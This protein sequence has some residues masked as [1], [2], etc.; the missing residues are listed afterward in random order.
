VAAKIK[1]E[2]QLK[3]MKGIVL[4]DGLSAEYRMLPID[5]YNMKLLGCGEDERIKRIV[6]RKE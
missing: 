2:E 5:N 3:S 6:A 4:V 1:L